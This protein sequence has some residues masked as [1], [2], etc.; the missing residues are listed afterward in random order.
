MP[1]VRDNQQQC[2][3]SQASARMRD[4]ASRYWQ[5]LGDLSRVQSEHMLQLNLSSVPIATGMDCG[6]A[7]EVCS[8]AA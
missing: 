4:H 7:A 5:H 2:N 6:V 3:N 8:R 1:A